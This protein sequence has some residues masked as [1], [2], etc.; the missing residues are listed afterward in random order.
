MTEL[1]HEDK[2]LQL[3]RHE[4]LSADVSRLRDSKSSGHYEMMWERTLGELTGGRYDMVAGLRF[5]VAELQAANEKQAF[6]DLAAL[7]I[8]AGLTDPG[9]QRRQ[10][11][12]EAYDMAEIL[13]EERR[14]RQLGLPYVAPKT[15]GIPF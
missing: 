10:F 1:S 6:L 5:F 13:W 8:I 9:E 7:K 4:A 14:R 11:A 12:R 3:A 2:K 15:E